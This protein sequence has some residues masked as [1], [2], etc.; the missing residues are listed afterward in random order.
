MLYQVVTEDGTCTPW[1]PADPILVLRTERPCVSHPPG[2]FFFGVTTCAS[3]KGLSVG[4]PGRH[5]IPRPL[6]ARI[7]RAYKLRQQP[8]GSPGSVDRPGFFFVAV[9]ALFLNDVDFAGMCVAAATLNFYS[10][11]WWVMGGTDDIVGD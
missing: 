4:R 11:R 5:L 7:T 10:R 6:A 1:V 9:K 3:R 2:L 8:L